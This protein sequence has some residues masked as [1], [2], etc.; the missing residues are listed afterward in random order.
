MASSLNFGVVGLGMGMH[1]CKALQTA[2]G[3]ALVAVC[4]TD[5][6]RLNRAAKQFGCRGYARYADLLRDP[7]VDAVCV[8]TE[9]GKHAKMAMQAAR[10]GKHLIVEKPVDVR[11]AAVTELESVVKAAGVKCGCVFQYRMDNCNRMLKAAIEKGKMGNLI[12]VHAH[13][14]W[15]RAQSYYDGPHGAWRGTWRWDGGGSLMNQGIHT[16]DL[17]IFLAGPVHSVAGFYGVYNHRIQAEDQVVAVLQFANGAL[18]TLY[19]TTCAVPEGA[20]RVY[21]Y[22]TRGSFSRHGDTLEFCEMGTPRERKRMMDLFGGK[23]GKDAAS[24]DPMAVS[25]DGHL[26]IIE[27]LVKAVQKDREPVIPLAAARHAVDV[28]CAV[29]RSG[30]TGRVVKIS[31]A[32]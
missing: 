25:A 31:E 29:Y 14:P 8:V 11:P 26:L 22:G 10:A 20:Q 4:D 30:K 13:L 12:G 19:T 1:H 9:S 32:Q 6:A 5:E 15:F 18:G 21:I 17:A 3:A 27:D 24:S 7:S 16:L 2:K 28:A 23:S